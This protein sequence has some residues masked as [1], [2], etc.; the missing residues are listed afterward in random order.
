MSPCE[1]GGVD[2]YGE[3]MAVGSGGGHGMIVI[4]IGMVSI[5]VLSLLFPPPVFP[6]FLEAE[7][8]LPR[9]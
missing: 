4:V 9:M 2:Y 5:S 7:Y 1:C 8:Q 6:P 3:E